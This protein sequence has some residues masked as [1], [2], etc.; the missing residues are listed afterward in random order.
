MMNN[1][2][3]IVS[4]IAFILF[5][6][7]CMS[8]TETTT[9][10]ETNTKTTMAKETATTQA[11]ASPTTTVKPSG[12]IVNKLTNLASAMSAGVAYKCTY[13]Y[14][15]VQSEGWVKGE[16]YYFKTTMPETTGY[17]VS[18][19]V[20]MYSWE[21]GQNKGY[22]FNIEEMKK[23]A[24]SQQQ[25]Y[26]DMKQVSSSANNVVCIPEVASDSKFTPPSGIQFQDMGELLKQ[27]QNAQKGGQMP[28]LSAYQ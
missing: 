18:D 13:S 8:V 25:G 10:Q 2:L 15:N 14:N 19:G 23:Q 5:V 12:G 7:G 27:M 17:A 26:Q 24:N 21:E 28:D 9:T 3:K 16:K 4:L 22:K 11:K 20:W 1:T 6:S